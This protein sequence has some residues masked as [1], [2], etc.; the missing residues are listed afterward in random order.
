[1]DTYYVVACS[2]VHKKILPESA[3]ELT[4]ASISIIM[5]HA[6]GIKCSV[7]SF[8]IHTKIRCLVIIVINV[9]NSKK[10]SHS[11][12]RLDNGHEWR[13]QIVVFL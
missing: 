9:T 12:S 11:A 4:S 2:Q 10:L 1:M 6:Q 5:H 7:L 8:A 3:S 13:L